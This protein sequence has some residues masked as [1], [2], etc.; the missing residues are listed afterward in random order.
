MAFSTP[1]S[2]FNYSRKLTLQRQP[3]TATLPGGSLMPLQLGSPHEAL[4]ASFTAKGF[5][6]QVYAVNVFPQRL[7]CFKR[8]GADW[9]RHHATRNYRAHHLTG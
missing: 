3:G 1:C 9:T 6:A 7:A 4:P 5:L 8:H 2:F